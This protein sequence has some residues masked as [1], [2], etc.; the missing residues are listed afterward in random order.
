MENKFT[1]RGFTFLELI[2]SIA[3]AGIILGSLYSTFFLV[4]R[5][6]EFDSNSI[7]RLEEARNILTTLRIELE[8]TYLR[9]GDD[10]TY[11][12][13][14]DRD[15]YGRDASGI[16]F[17]TMASA[18]GL[19][20][21]SY[22]VEESNNRPILIKEGYPA[23]RQGSLKAELLED[24]EGFL[25]IAFDRGREFRTWDSS[26]HG[27]IPEIVRITLSFRIGERMVRLTE[28]VRMKRPY[29]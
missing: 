25:V 26:I 16:S 11:F 28:S 8:S 20:S 17:T 2:I 9:T 12:I 6:T 18:T 5:I 3:I 4:H 23:F 1:L 29:I 15:Y 7:V 13:I 22:S 21:I 27:G 24:L 19:N 10:R 14:K